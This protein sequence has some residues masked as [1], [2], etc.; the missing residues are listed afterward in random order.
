MKF[1]N[2]L[3]DKQGIAK[4]AN[5][6]GDLFR[7]EGYYEAALAYFEKCI[8][9]HEEINNIDKKGIAIVTGNIGLTGTGVISVATAE[10]LPEDKFEPVTVTEIA[11]AEVQSGLDAG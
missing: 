9:I 1:A 6:V 10:D 5:N 8:K 7:T 3:D 11:T 4:I 2:E